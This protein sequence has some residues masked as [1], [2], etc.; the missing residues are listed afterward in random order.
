MQLSHKMFMIA[1][2]TTTAFAMPAWAADEVPPAVQAFLDGIER[3]TSVEPTYESLEEDGDG[4]V[5]ITNLT[6][7]KPADEL[8]SPS[9]THEDRRDRVLGH[10][11]RRRRHFPDRQR[12]LLEHDRRGEGQGLCHQHGHSRRQRGRLVRLGTGRQPHAA[13]GDARQHDVGRPQDERGKWTITAMGQTYSVDGYEQT[14]DGDPKTGA[15]TFAMKVTNIAIPEAAIA[16]LDQGGM[17][18]QLGYTA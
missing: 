7:A 6:I 11:G 8:T 2:L 4:T 3:Q 13:A 14:W 17:L 10:R 9:V 16:M 1:C 18:K 15:G 5:T 12:H